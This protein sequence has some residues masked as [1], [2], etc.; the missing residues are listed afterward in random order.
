MINGG[1]SVYAKNV[2]DAYISGNNN[3]NSGSIIMGNQKIKKIHNNQFN[4]S[5][6][7]SGNMSTHGHS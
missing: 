7:I 2:A 1:G 3:L 4:Q 5:K 6:Y